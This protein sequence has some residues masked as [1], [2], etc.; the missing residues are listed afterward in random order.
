MHTIALSLTVQYDGEVQQPQTLT[1]VLNRMVEEGRKVIEANVAHPV[2]RD[3]LA[4]LSIGEFS[5]ASPDH[6]AAAFDAIM[7]KLRQHGLGEDASVNG[8]DLVD[9]MN[10]V[11][12]EFGHLQDAAP[13][14]RA[15]GV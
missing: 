10:D 4:R 7:A 13:A 1:T 12:Q 9:A 6:K 15:A 8:G 11:I 5:L 3:K 2:A 14:A